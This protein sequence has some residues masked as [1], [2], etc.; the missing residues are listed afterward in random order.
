LYYQHH[1]KTYSTLGLQK[2]VEHPTIHACTASSDAERNVSENLK[3][4]RCGK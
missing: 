2:Y 4:L 3:Y 1:H